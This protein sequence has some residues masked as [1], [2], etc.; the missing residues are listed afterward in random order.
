[1]EVPPLIKSFTKCGWVDYTT[2]ASTGRSHHQAFK[3]T[4]F[5][6]ARAM[7]LQEMV[8]LKELHIKKIL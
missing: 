3:K 5:R 7:Q 6:E 4:G 1:M 8:V 2:T